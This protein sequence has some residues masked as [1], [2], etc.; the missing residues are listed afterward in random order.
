MDDSYF[1]V[2]FSGIIREL[3]LYFKKKIPI[4]N[5]NLSVDPEVTGL[6]Q[7]IQIN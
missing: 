5:I 1:S 4:Q 2:K 7:M 3:R 6:Q